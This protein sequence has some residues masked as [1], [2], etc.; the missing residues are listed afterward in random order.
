MTIIRANG[1]ALMFAYFFLLHAAMA[2]TCSSTDSAECGS[3]TKKGERMDFTRNEEV[4][5]LWKN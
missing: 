4:F 1:F 2:S 3:V 5:N